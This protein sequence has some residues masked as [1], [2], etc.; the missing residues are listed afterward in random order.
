MSEQIEHD[1]KLNDYVH[2]L[3]RMFPETQRGFASITEGKYKFFPEKDIDMPIFFMALK[4]IG[5]NCPGLRV[6]RIKKTVCMNT[7]C[8]IILIRLSRYKE[9]RLE[10]LGYWVQGYKKF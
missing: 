4:K 6:S 10:A 2:K 9:S 1:R 3:L 7:E 5:D 8:F